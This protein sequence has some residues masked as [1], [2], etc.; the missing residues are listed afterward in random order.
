MNEKEFLSRVGNYT[1]SLLRIYTRTGPIHFLPSC[2]TIQMIAHVNEKY[3]VPSLSERFNCPIR[4][5]QEWK[6]HVGKNP[7]WK[8]Y[9]TLILPSLVAEVLCTENRELPWTILSPNLNENS[10]IYFKGKVIGVKE[11]IL[12]HTPLK[13]KE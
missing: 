11:L 8:Q 3:E 6:L 1:S 13:R 10:A 5:P 2:A 7:L 9:D 4:L 12:H